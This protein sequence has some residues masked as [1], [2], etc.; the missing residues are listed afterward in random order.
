MRA[1]NAAR[2]GFTESN[3]SSVEAAEK[4]FNQAIKDQA[5]AGEDAWAV[6]QGRY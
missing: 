3:K 2:N 5:S 1:L 6:K 4:N